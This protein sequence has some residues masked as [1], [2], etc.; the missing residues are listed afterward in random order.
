MRGDGRGVV[1]GSQPM[2]YSCTQEPINFWRSNSMFNIWLA[3][4]TNQWIHVWVCVCLRECG[5]VRKA[6]KKKKCK[7]KKGETQKVRLRLYFSIA[8]SPNS[9]RDSIL[10]RAVQSSFKTGLQISVKRSVIYR[11]NIYLFWQKLVF[12]LQIGDHFF[13]NLNSDHFS[14]ITSS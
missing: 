4:R 1:S 8:Q 9:E 2:I 11:L 3:A 13:L 7:R 5:G 12:T 14:W 6:S 10:P